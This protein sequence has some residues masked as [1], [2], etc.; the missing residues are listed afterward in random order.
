MIN[1]IRMF[2]AMIKGLSSYFKFDDKEN[3]WEW[4]WG[5]TPDERYSG[6]SLWETWDTFK[7][8]ITLRH[9][10]FN[11][12]MWYNIH[13]GKRYYGYSYTF[14]RD[15]YFVKDSCTLG[16]WFIPNDKTFSYGSVNSYDE[17]SNGNI[18]VC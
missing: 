15:G 8:T 17:Y 6:E 3:F 10:R 11:L 16:W 7:Y 5:Q 13:F 12:R 1:T 14:K 9:L 18:F 2:K 4:Y